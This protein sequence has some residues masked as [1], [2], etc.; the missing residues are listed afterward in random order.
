MMVGMVAV[1]LPSSV[2]CG[3]FRLQTDDG[4]DLK[5]LI[6]LVGACRFFFARTHRG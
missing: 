3:Q 6:E 2:A 5:V 4:S 1:V